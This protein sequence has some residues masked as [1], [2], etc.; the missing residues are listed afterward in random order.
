MRK[1]LKSLKGNMFGLVWFGLSLALWRA[2]AVASEM[3][4]H[5]RLNTSDFRF[6][7]QDGYDVIIPLHDKMS[8]TSIP[9]HPQL[10]SWDNYPVQE[11]DEGLVSLKIYDVSGRC[12]QIVF[13]EE[14]TAGYYDLSIPVTSF[15]DGAYFLRLE[16]V[17]R[18]ITRKVLVK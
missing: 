17:N 18:A 12:V 8:H 3:V 13:S 9:G 7:T 1:W 6:E 2:E 4:V 15:S 5:L 16:G 11:E 10:S 14:K